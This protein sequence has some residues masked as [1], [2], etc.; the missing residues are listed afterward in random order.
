MRHSRSVVPTRRVALGEVWLPHDPAPGPGGLLL[1]AIVGAFVPRLS[2]ELRA[3][4]ERL[5]W[6]LDRGRRIAQPRLRHRFQTDVVGLDRSKH[7]LLRVGRAFGLE[8]DDHG[9]PLPQILAA[10]Y[11]ASKL[12]VRARPQVFRLLRRATRWEGEADERLLA[13]LTDNRISSQRD[14]RWALRIL[15]L[16][17]ATEPARS[18]VLGAFR[19]L[20]RDAHPDHGADINGAGVRISELA[21]AKSILLAVP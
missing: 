15:G 6:D 16:H 19:R 9:A 10:A 18:D 8:L 14:Q 17:A 4:V 2:E 5:V 3:G 1:A 13:F 7:Q 20:V 21:T 12:S 11:A